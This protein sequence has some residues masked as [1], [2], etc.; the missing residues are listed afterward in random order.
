MN[1]AA[2]V[3]RIMQAPPPSVYTPTDWANSRCLLPLPV[4]CL[5]PRVEHANL[6]GQPFD[7]QF[8][9]VVLAHL[10]FE[11]SVRDV[12]LFLDS[13]RGEDVDVCTFVPTAAEVAH[14]DQAAAHER[15]QA[16][17]RL[18]E[19]DGERVRQFALRG[20]RMLGQIGEQA[21]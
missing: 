15:V 5:P 1:P 4:V 18:A 8:Q 17:V 21:V 19:T 2:P 9:I 14:L 20:L 6:G 16:V 11:E 3:T 13:F 7:F 12:D 10:P